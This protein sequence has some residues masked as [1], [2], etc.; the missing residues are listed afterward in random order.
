MNR[1]VLLTVSEVATFL[2]T[3]RGTLDYWR[4]LDPPQGPPFIRIGRRIAY[5]EA[6]LIA[7]VDEH[8]QAT[9]TA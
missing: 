3:P 6:E 4:T 8:R 7:W 9:K 5:D 2:R 1:P